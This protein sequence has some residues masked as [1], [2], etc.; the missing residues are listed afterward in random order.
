MPTIFRI[1]YPK[2]LLAILLLINLPILIVLFFLSKTSS[3]L[4]NAVILIAVGGGLNFAIHRWLNSFHIS[5]YPDKLEMSVLPFKRTL[6]KTD[7]ADVSIIDWRRERSLRPSWRLFGTSFGDYNVGKF[8]LCGKKSALLLST[9]S[10]N[11][12]IE[13]KKGELILLS[14]PDFERFIGCFKIFYKEIKGA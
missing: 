8:R 3:S 4:Y 2:S 13:T 11:L 12:L 1:P 14:P 9:S 7:I 6:T 10:K 5:I